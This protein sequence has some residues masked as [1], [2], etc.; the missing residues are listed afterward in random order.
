MKKMTSLLI[1]LPSALILISLA[2]AN[3]HPVRLALN[4]F[5]PEDS[6]LAI[7]LPFYVYLLGALI[8]GVALG[9]IATWFNQGRWRQTARH[10]TLEARRWQAETE[11]LARERDEMVTSGKSATGQSSTGNDRG[12]QLAVAN[13]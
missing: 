3:R 5:R 11:R 12:R 9:G 2:L 8:A 7:Q 1:A 10:R 4:P 13:R 6:V